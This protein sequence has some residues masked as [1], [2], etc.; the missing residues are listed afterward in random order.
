MEKEKLQKCF[1]LKI[2]RYKRCAWYIFK[3]TYSLE[4]ISDIE[5]ELFNEAFDN[6]IWG[7]NKNYIGNKME[8][9]VEENLWII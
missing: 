5:M 9:R 2:W 1:F 4:E 8:R 3:Y 7:K 6:Y